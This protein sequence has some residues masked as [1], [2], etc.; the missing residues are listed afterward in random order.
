[1]KVVRSQHQ[2][3]STSDFSEMSGILS[4]PGRAFDGDICLGTAHV[5]SLPSGRN[6]NRQQSDQERGMLSPL[7]E[8]HSNS[9]S[10]P[11]HTP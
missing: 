5:E 1:M 2:V 4:G 6:S 7:S 3:N 8:S 10:A 11:K 9:Y